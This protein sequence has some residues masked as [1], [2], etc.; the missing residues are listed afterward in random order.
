MNTPEN[1]LIVVFTQ[2]EITALYKAFLEVIEDLQND[3]RIMLGKVSEKS[4][5]DFARA[6]DF[7]TSEKYEQIRKR[8][9][10]QGNECSRKMIS[11]LDFFDFI[12]NKDKVEEAARQKRQVVKKVVISSP[13][14]VE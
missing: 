4:G 7:F 10:D 6:I 2:R 11:F 12:I 14:M 1:N 8:I 9:L 3:H 13:L 5:A